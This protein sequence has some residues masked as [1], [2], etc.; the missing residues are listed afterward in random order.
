MNPIFSFIIHKSEFAKKFLLWYKEVYLGDI[1]IFKEQ[2][3]IEQL[4]VYLFYIDSVNGKCII[5]DRTGY[6]V[7]H[8]EYKKHPVQEKD[9]LPMITKD[10]PVTN[11]LTNYG[12]AVKYVFT[13]PDLP[14]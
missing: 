8:T 10:N 1:A 5:A 3:F 14:F 13:L 7:Y 2:S 4:G 9:V 11:S 12:E 6:K